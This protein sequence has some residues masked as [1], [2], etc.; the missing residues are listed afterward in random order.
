MTDNRYTF[1][2]FFNLNQNQILGLENHLDR[3]WDRKKSVLIDSSYFSEKIN[4]RIMGSLFSSRFHNYL[5][6]TIRS[7]L[8][9]ECET[10]NLIQEQEKTIIKISNDSLKKRKNEIMD[11][12]STTIS[13]SLSQQSVYNAMENKLQL[14]YN[15]DIWLYKIMSFL[16]FFVACASFFCYHK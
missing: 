6:N 16:S 8:L 4:D 12:V 1:F 3:W 9:K 7:Y 5:T 11:Y 15:N 10:K 13:Q 2:D 14:Y